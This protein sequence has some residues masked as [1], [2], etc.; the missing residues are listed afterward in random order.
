MQLAEIQRLVRFPRTYFRLIFAPWQAVPEA[1][2]GSLEVCV[3]D[4]RTIIS[5]RAIHA[6]HDPVV[7]IGVRSRELDGE[8]HHLHV[9]FVVTEEPTLPERSGTYPAQESIHQLS[10]PAGAITI[11][12]FD[13]DHS[14]EHGLDLT[15][16]HP[17]LN[18]RHAP[19]SSIVRRAPPGSAFC[20]GN[21]LHWFLVQ[22]MARA[23]LH[24]QHERTQHHD[25][26]HHF[27]RF[28]ET[29]QN[30]ARI[31]TKKKAR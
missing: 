30:D 26:A 1:R 10:S 28:H 22:R 6:S 4:H 8:P 24:R 14:T 23:S 5:G 11:P 20:F 19:A 18:L 13:G 25:V 2:P 27:H 7:I 29:L 15:R 3:A 12:L 16:V 9:S 31:M 21:L 17:F